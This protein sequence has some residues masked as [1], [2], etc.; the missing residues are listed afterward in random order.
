MRPGRCGTRGHLNS[1]FI[2]SWGLR[3]WQGCFWEGAWGAFKAVLAGAWKRV[4]ETGNLRTDKPLPTILDD[5]KKSQR[6]VV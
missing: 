2:C 3:E 6:F 1:A 4:K 5:L